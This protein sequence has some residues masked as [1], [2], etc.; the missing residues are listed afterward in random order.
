MSSE[1]P[2]Y[3]T[4]F[5][6][7]LEDWSWTY[8][9]GFFTNIHYMLTKDYLN[10]ACYTTDYT[11][12]S[13]GSNVI[14]FLYPHWIKKQY[15]IEG[16]V[17]GQFTISIISGLQGTVTSYK[18]RLMKVDDLG[19]IDEIGSTGTIVPVN[20][21]YAY[22][23]G[24]GVGDEGVYQFYMTVSPEKKVLDKERLYVEITLVVDGTLGV[25]C[26]YH[27]ND[28][29]WEDFKISIPFRGL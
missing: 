6:I 12:L 23:P 20:N 13:N 16:V 19:T 4:M 29:T 3:E 26:L 24:L 11:T 9:N 1:L 27:S 25:M 21:F 15:Y 28:S 8:G 5:G 17:E 22:D 2:Y 7:V 14:M 10:E 18:I